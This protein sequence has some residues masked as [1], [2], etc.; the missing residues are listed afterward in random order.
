MSV[1][2]ELTALL[3][4]V[5]SRL[6]DAEPPEPPFEQ[7]RG[8]PRAEWA[9]RVAAA[10][11][12][13]D[14]RAR[15]RRTAVDR[16]AR[17]LFGTDL[18]GLLPSADGLTRHAAELP[19]I[20]DAA[21][22]R[23]VPSL[24]GAPAASIPA[25]VAPRPVPVHV[26]TP[27]APRAAI[28]RLHGGA[29]WMGGGR[30][31]GIIDRVLLD[32]LASACSAIVVDVDYRLAP[33]HPFPAAILDAVHALERVRAH[34]DR[35]GIDPGRVAL[36]G[37]SSG[38]N[39]A[40][41]AAIAEA[42]GTRRAPLAALGLVVPSVDATTA[43]PVVRDDPEAWRKRRRLL[44]GYLGDVAPADPRVSPALRD[45][46]PGLPPT[47]AAIAEFDEV[48]VGGEAL[49]RAIR[50]GGGDAEAR[51]YAMTHTTATPDVEAAVVRDLAAFLSARLA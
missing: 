25:P 6:D 51:V 4:A 34:V 31:P 49:C 39:I 44:R 45:E 11:A 37:T 2:P 46:L 50:R 1:P 16:A 38:A 8:E 10:R 27:P 29:F 36:V 40:A 13:H 17:E 3:E 15:E 43:P 19:P 28:V 5:H 48:A 32:S 9:R 22:L 33:E 26:T 35:L 21:L 42:E 41:I 47:L 18:A 12:A 23:G 7:P 30:T 14:A 20:S 24:H